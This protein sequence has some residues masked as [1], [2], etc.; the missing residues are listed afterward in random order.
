[1]WPPLSLR[2]RAG[3]RVAG[4]IP[5]LPRASHPAPHGT[6]LGLGWGSG[7]ALG[8]T[9]VGVPLIAEGGSTHVGALGLS[10]GVRGLA[11]PTGAWLC[12]L[13]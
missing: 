13:R 7:H 12:Q 4:S 2:L 11:G 9:G 6:G 5:L 3:D 1:M 8:G 10:V